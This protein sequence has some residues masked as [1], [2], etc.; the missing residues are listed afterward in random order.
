MDLIAGV[1]GVSR[2]PKE[3]PGS[4]S[5][6]IIVVPKSART[7]VTRDP[8]EGEY[9]TDE[10]EIPSD[11]A[12]RNA[13]LHGPRGSFSNE[14]SERSNTRVNQKKGE[15]CGRIYYG[16][17][18]YSPMRRQREDMIQPSTHSP[19]SMV[20]YAF[21]SGSDQSSPSWY[22]MVVPPQPSFQPQ[23]DVWSGWRQC[24]AFDSGVRMTMEQNV[25]VNQMA[26]AITVQ[27]NVRYGPNATTS[28]LQPPRV[29]S[30]AMQ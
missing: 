14:N 3:E 7:W 15:N 11:N 9:V 2:P 5:S 30:M 17:P 24:T 16:I 21:P 23:V 27:S 10:I 6:P 26:H 12:N 29:G 25:R 8:P 18:P 13:P 20:P 22:N 28:F 19:V 1:N 4:V